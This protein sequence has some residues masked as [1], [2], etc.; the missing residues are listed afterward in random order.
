MTRTIIGVTV[1]T[2]I[3]PRTIKE[4]LQPVLSVNG[5]TPDKN[6]NVKIAMGNVDFSMDEIVQAVISE[7]PV[8]NG[9][10]LEE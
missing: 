2:S 8:Y 3:S 5:K 6:G 7:L 1:G 9:E 10:V 4:K